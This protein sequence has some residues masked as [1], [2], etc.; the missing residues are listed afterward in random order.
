[1]LVSPALLESVRSL[2]GCLTI[3]EEMKRGFEYAP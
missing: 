2:E 3:S 1:M